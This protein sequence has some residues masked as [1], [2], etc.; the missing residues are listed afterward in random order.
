[1]SISAIEP[2][3]R[4]VPLPIAGS[5]VLSH[6]A[7]SHDISAR[8]L[9][10]IL[11]R[12]RLHMVFQPILNLRARQ[13]FGYEALVR[14]PQDSALHSPAA[15]FAAADR[16]G[17][18]VELE[19]QCRAHAIAGFAEQRLQGKLFINMSAHLLGD[20]EQTH[21]GIG[22]LLRKVGMRP[23]DII[24][25]ITE[26]D[27]VSDFSIFREVLN[28][29]RSYG[30]QFAIDDLGEGFSNLRMWSEIRPE[31]VKIDRHFISGISDDMLKFRLVRSMAEI[32]E[33]CHATLIAEGIETEAE[34][35]TL[36][37]MGIACGQGFF[38]AL[39]QSEPEREADA[40]LLRLL[41]KNQISVFP[42]NTPSHSANSIA[43]LL[44]LVAPVSPEHDNETLL[45]YFER[46]PDLHALPVVDDEVPI[47]M[48]NRHLLAENFSRPYWREIYGR[49]SCTLCMDKHPIIVDL[50]T[51]VQAVGNLF[52]Q[53]T[54]HQIYDGFIITENGEYIGVGDTR[55]LMVHI[56]ELQIKAARYANPLTQL[57][58][59]VPISEH[60][61][62]LID[63]ASPFV[64][65]YVDICN[66][67]PYN[68]I[69]GFRRGDEVI[70]TLGALLQQVCDERLDFIGHIGGD[71]FMLLMQS[72]DWLLR[73]HKIVREF[74]ERM[75]N[76]VDAP[77]L[78]RGGLRGEDRRGHSVFHPLPAL[79][80][81]CLPVAPNSFASHIE[82]S[83]AVSE[84]KRQSKKMDKDKI[85][86][87]R[88]KF[89]GADAIH[90]L[91]LTSLP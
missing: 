4:V 71:D 23:D 46:D 77:D 89:V 18:R 10:D 83:A 84:A 66:F 56:T 8:L 22:S 17:L 32:A 7:Q 35:T 70:Q 52:G 14:G 85:F 44:K 75:Q 65:C 6:P 34:F 73:C 47:G 30:Y 16:H 1:M 15:L 20:T 38:I 51:P 86:I 62:R 25:E 29:Y 33:A 3:G 13:F 64:A 69:Y 50:T 59:N 31:Y 28:R 11:A 19:N 36:R 24:I 78:Q 26:N 27:R 80:I 61:M 43:P 42:Q 2:S 37:D 45:T 5:A 57:P 21:C 76:L 48:I 41:D 54:R 58:G 53:A 67:K 40:K 81:G 68:D 60:M 87:E 72:K 74:D 91:P 49:R 82:V 9:R 63:S 90:A 12:K 55:E 39:P 88:R 79:S